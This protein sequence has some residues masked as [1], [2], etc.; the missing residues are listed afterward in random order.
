MVVNRGFSF[1][2]IVGMYAIKPDRAT[3]KDCITAIYP[4]NLKRIY[5]QNSYE[6]GSIAY[7]FA[8]LNTNDTEKMIEFCAHY[9]LLKSNRLTR[10][11][12]NNYIY[13][14]EYKSVF[15]EVVPDYTPDSYPLKDFIH[16][17]KTMKCLL[18]IKNGIDTESSC[19]ILLNLLPLLLCYR[20]IPIKTSETAR[21]NVL[22]NM[23]ATRYYDP[24]FLP[25]MHDYNECFKGALTDII[26]QLSAAI[27][28]DKEEW[29][30]TR[31][32]SED[33]YSDA[34]QCTW[35]NYLH[36]L[37]EILTV[38]EIST[39]EDYEQILFTNNL[40]DE[41]LSKTNLSYEQIK[42]AGLC[43]ISDFFN[44]Y[45]ANVTPELRYENN[46]LQYDWK[47]SSLLEAMYMELMVSFSPN[48]QTKRCANPTCN[49]FF[50]VAKG[51]SRKIY[52]SQRCALLMAKRK[53]RE[54]MKK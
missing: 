49:S 53:Q 8:A 2:N 15:S 20:E 29:F 28:A 35:Q 33:L 32:F 4:G 46:I 17:I 31:E 1:S 39:S 38:T 6:E 3:S 36:I 48:S 51:N 5:S 19:E 14:K 18:G 23:Y 42:Q 16:E 52:C 25:S 34:Y 27:N 10:N 37:E 44:S 47:I 54:R 40:T 21:F 45:T 26:E 24:E 13:F 9:G 30:Y 11:T 41:L 50:E 7:E 12:T 22:F 43:C